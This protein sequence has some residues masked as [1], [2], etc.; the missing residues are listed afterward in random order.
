MKQDKC[1]DCKNTEICKFYEKK[2]TYFTNV[3]V[4]ITSCKYYLTAAQF[5]NNIT[6]GELSPSHEGLD[7]PHAELKP[8]T[9]LKEF[10]YG[11]KE[12]TIRSFYSDEDSN[13]FDLC[14]DCG[15]KI[16]DEEQCTLDVQTNSCFCQ[17]C[18]EGKGE[19][20]ET[21]KEE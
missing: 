10:D 2:S 3:G 5:S 20:E 18:W 14:A 7:I 9:E 15:K 8:Y 16:E 11:D 21:N 17:K 13:S 12:E 4:D 6:H 19:K 1:Y